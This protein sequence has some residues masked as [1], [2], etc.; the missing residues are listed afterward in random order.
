M[1]DHSSV[2]E[3]MDLHIKAGGYPYVICHLE[4][5]SVVNPTFVSTLALGS[6]LKNSDVPTK[7]TLDTALSAGENNDLRL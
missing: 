6:N 5:R 3:A 4:G 7:S 1:Q 2:I